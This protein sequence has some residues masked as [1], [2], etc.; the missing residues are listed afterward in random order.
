[1]TTNDSL[2]RVC[3]ALVLIAFSLSTCAQS[4][5]SI[6]Q[7]SLQRTACFGACPVY[8][9]SIYADGLVEFH[10]ER[11]VDFPGNYTGRVDP[12]NF[13]ELTNFADRLNFFDLAE[14]YRVRREADGTVVTVSDLPSR[15]I[16]V[17]A[18]E[19]VKSVL[20]YFAGPAEL[21]QFELLIDSMTNSAQ[22]TGRTNPNL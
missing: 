18:G 2:A 21:E 20:N 11:F 22:W 10:G 15:I 9:V 3:T 4:N 19:R 1:M 7:I 16:K 14:E 8:T 5:S 17:I 13:T 6:S 12:A